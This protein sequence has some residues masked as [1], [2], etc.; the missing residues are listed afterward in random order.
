VKLW[1]MN[2]KSCYFLIFTLHVLFLFVCS[3]IIT[4]QVCIIWCFHMME[5]PNYILF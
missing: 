4:I 1:R 5:L 2:G 3:W